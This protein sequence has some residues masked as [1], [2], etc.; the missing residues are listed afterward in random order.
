MRVFSYYKKGKGC[1]LQNCH[2]TLFWWHDLPRL[3]T[4]Q[5]MWTELD[6]TCACFLERAAIILNYTSTS[7]V[8]IIRA[9]LALVL[10]HGCWK[11]AHYQGIPFA[12]GIRS[13]FQTIRSYFSALPRLCEPAIVKSVITVGILNSVFES[14]A[15]EGTAP[16]VHS[17]CQ[18]PT[19]LF[20]LSVAWG[21]ELER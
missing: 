9:Q 17:V 14:L 6:H 1:P 19:C 11:L 10:S 5:P 20:P 2:P 4:S 13:Q 12:L 3:W 15:R 7:Y 8:N 21:C 16:G 18:I